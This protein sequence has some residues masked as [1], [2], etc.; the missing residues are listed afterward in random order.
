EDLPPAGGLARGRFLAAHL[1]SV[2]ATPAAIGGRRRAGAA[3]GVPVLRA[4]LRE[5]LP[6][7]HAAGRTGEDPARLGVTRAGTPSCC[8]RRSG[9]VFA[10]PFLITTP[11]RWVV[12][13]GSPEHGFP[14]QSDEPGF[15][16]A[17]INQP[18]GPARSRHPPESLAGTPPEVDGFS[19]LG[20][21]PG[22]LATGASAPG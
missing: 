9:S 6:D 18:S 4:A 22:A 15:P 1:H 11:R 14:L 20:M 17:E 13:L 8:R 5:P 7:D 10:R 12:T 21:V 16:Q 19:A 2:L 3:A